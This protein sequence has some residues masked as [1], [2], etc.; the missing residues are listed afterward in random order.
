MI[1]YANKDNIPAT[2]KSIE[3]DPYRSAYIALVFYADG[4]KSYI[5]CPAKLNVGDVI[6]SG[7]DSEI[8]IGNTLPLENIPTGSIIH[9]VELTIHKGAQLSKVCWFLCYING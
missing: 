6:I 8:S 4:A 9:N 2:V 5:I 7:P 1:F 3:Y